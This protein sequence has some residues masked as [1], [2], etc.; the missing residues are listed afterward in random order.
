MT[1]EEAH[2]FD[3]LCGSENG[4]ANYP[5][6]SVHPLRSR[7]SN[8]MCSPQRRSL[9]VWCSKTIVDVQDELVFLCQLAQPF[10]VDHVQCRI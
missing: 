9:E 10:E 8:E 1:G 7:V 3:Q 5:S 4:S 2:F 6:L